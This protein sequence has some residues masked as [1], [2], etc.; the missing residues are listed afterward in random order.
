M[1]EIDK[2]IVIQ[3]QYN[4]KT[5]FEKWTDKQHNGCFIGKWTWFKEDLKE[6]DFF[7][8]SENEV[9]KLIYNSMDKLVNIKSGCWESEMEDVLKDWKSKR[10][11]KK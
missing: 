8:V 2:Y 10:G 5:D 11:D 3:K 9:K 6:A 7:V 1:T 4:N